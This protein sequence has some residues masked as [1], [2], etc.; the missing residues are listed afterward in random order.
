MIDHLYIVLMYTLLVILLSKCAWA[1]RGC[2]FAYT[3]YGA[4]TGH[5]GQ[6]HRCSHE[7]PSSS[8]S[9]RFLI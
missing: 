4:I 8:P 2:G 6:A 7:T 3:P 5:S 9:L 1:G